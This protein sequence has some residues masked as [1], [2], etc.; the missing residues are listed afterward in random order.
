[1]LFVDLTFVSVLQ[2]YIKCAKCQFFFS[3][4]EK[5]CTFAKKNVI[6]TYPQMKE[7]GIY[8]GVN[9]SFFSDE[10]KNILN[11]FAKKYWKVTRAEK[12]SL[13]NSIY[14]IVLIKPTE[15]ISHGFNLKREVVVVFSS[16][17]T[18]QPR[19]IEAID[20]KNVQSLRVE[21]IC[22]I[23]ISKDN[24]IE[25]QIT[26]LIKTN[27]E[28]RVIVPFSYKELLEN[29]N[30]E[31]YI[32]NK[33]RK[34]FYSRDLFGIQ[35]PLKKDIYFFG[36][37][38]IIQT[39]VNRHLNN[40][41][42]GLF[43]LRKTGKTSILYG[44]ER[45]LDRKN[46]ISVFV[47]CQTLHMKSWN[48][49]LYYI[50]EQLQLKGTSV[51]NKDI[52]S[53]KEYSDDSY[54]SDYFEKD[55]LTIGKKNKKRILLIFDEIEHITFG[56]SLSKGWCSGDYFIKFWQSIRSA[57]QKHTKGTF[58]YLITGTNPRCV[59]EATI[60]HVD[61]PIFMQFNPLFIPPFS[62]SQTEEMVNKLGGYM[63][64]TFDESTCAS[65]M[66]DFGGHPL[67]IRQMCSFIHQSIK[68]DRPH[69]I[70]KIEYDGYKNKYYEQNS[71][72]SKYAEMVLSVLKNWYPDEYQMLEWL[73]VD[74]QSTFQ[75]LA[76]LSPSYVN[77]LKKYNIVIEHNGK[78]YFNNESLK[79]FLS[80]QNR[81]QKLH[82]TNEEKQREISERRNK[83]E[84]LLRKIV[85]QTLKLIYGEDEAKK[86]VIA[87]MYGKEK[88]GRYE[89]NDYMDFFDP[90]KHQ[91]F[92]LTLFN[93]IKK[94]WD[95]GFQNIFDCNKDLF[96]ARTTIINYNRK[97]DSHAAEI[98]DEQFQEFRGAMSWLEKKISENK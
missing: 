32:N 51:T 58:S 83:I 13:S 62:Y 59:E 8:S 44:I 53:Q 31:E 2:R 7:T 61:N 3:I 73:S 72:F 22:C 38:D 65:L 1:M 67:L 68:E 79:F 69:K 77:H 95:K 42:S 14:K 45:A 55:I 21:E 97:G 11:L 91:I 50:V 9:L 17:E 71:N 70:I 87:E 74:D 48:Q 54:A 78:Y 56:T 41:N 30:D 4:Q 35:D 12:I 18:F 25:N 85:R 33:I 29:G 39:L 49:A 88:I 20:Y 64:L 46:S 16:Y 23:I 82:L 26:Q 57:Y 40:E 28:A 76:S 37:S 52:H 75:G 80:N 15:Y 66:E 6:M 86:I 36:R 96:D 63:G 19:S 34:H 10:E 43:G 93:L 90:T 98:P 94:N 89:N 84:P 92:L 27:L 5:K 81:Y 24:D 60:N 47:D